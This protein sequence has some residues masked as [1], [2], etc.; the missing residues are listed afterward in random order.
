MTNPMC[1]LRSKVGIV[2]GLAILGMLGS[3]P[4]LAQENPLATP[5]GLARE[6]Y[7]AVSADPGKIPD[8]DRVRNLFLKEAVIVLRTSRAETTVFSLEGF[9]KDFVDFFDRPLTAKQVKASVSGFTER[10]VRVHVW[11]HWDIAHVLVLYEASVPGA[12]MPP[13]VG[14][15]SWS[16]VRR[17]GRWWVA[18]CTNDLV[19]REHPIPPGL[20]EPKR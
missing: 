7:T 6:V 1:T 9:I 3:V 16:L 11:Q 14:V 18:A 12:P 17:N 19:T 5:E 10:V 4:G 20:S 15:D 13:T 2:S 8:W